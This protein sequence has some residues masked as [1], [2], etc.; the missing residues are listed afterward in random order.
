MPEYKTG[1]IIAF[2]NY[3]W[4]VLD[5]SDDKTL[6]LSEKVIEEKWKPC[7]YWWKNNDM[8]KYLN[9][10]F[11]LN[12]TEEQREKIIETQINNP[13]NLWYGTD[14]GDDTYDKVFLLSLDEVDRYFGNSGDYKERRNETYGCFSNGHDPERIAFNNDGK[15]VRWFL[16]SR[17]EDFD[18]KWHTDDVHVIFTYQTIVRA[19]GRVD[20][21]GMGGF[22]SV[23]EES[24]GYEADGE[25]YT[26][27][28]RPAMWVRTDNKI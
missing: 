3:K 12:F 1:E 21:C 25:R 24:R 5:V 10:E 9:G 13:K 22:G 14:N 17:G 2:G 28:I 7:G 18:I 6:L 16:R 26:G 20:V 11:L 23:Y 4:R 15:A 27:C 8:R 19:D